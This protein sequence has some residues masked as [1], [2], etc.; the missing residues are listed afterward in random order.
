ML[1]KYL[2]LLGMTI[3]IFF[4]LVAT[5]VYPGGSLHDRNSPGFNWTKNFIS[6]L[7]GAKAV[8]G[9]DN[10]ARFWADAGIILLSVSFAIF[11]VNFSNKVPS[12]RIAKVIKYLGVVNIIFVSLI[13]TPLHNIMVPVASTLF[14]VCLFYITVFVMKSRLNFFKML[15]VICLLIFYY[16]F[17]LYSSANWTW[18]AIMQ[19]IAFVSSII[20]ILGLEYFTKKEY[21]ENT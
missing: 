1:R 15:C 8:N 2:V 12:R 14:L 6:N 11:F 18:L 9:F 16:T 5:M 7:F 17:Y 21:F 20:L 19:K 3:S 13:A 4:L 10:P